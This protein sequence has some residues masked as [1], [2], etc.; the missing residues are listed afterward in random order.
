M[1]YITEADKRHIEGKYHPLD[2][3]YDPYNRF[4]YNGYDYD[5]E[6][7]MDNEKIKEGLYALLDELDAKGEHHHVTKA[8]GFSFILDNTRIDVNE[9][10][11]FVGFN[12]WN[13]IMS[14]H[15]KWLKEVEQ[16]EEM[17]R[18]KALRDLCWDTGIITMWPDFDHTTPD[19]DAV[20]K[21]GFPGLLA[22]AEFYKEKHRRE[23]T[24]DSEKEAVFDGVI[25]TYQSI[26]RLINRFYEYSLTHG[27]EKSAEISACLK[28][29][30]EGAPQNTY[31][32]L[33][34]IYLYFMF[35]ESVDYYQ[36][37]TLGYGL[38][39]AIYPYMVKDIEEGR[40]TR[41]QIGTFIAHF[42]M[43]FSAIGNYWGQPFYLGGKHPDGRTKINE[44]S[45][46]IVEVYDELDIY[47]PKMQLKLDRSTP[48]DFRNK[49]LD[50]VRR[51]NGIF[52][53]ICEDGMV[54]ALMKS[55]H[56]YEEAL[57]AVITGCYEVKPKG[58]NGSGCTHLNMVKPLLLI[59]NGGKDEM[60]GKTL[61]DDV[62]P[63]AEL[64]TY[65]EFYREYIR[66]VSHFAEIAM[67]LED[68]YDPY[69]TYCNPANMMTGAYEEALIKGEDAY[70]KGIKNGS[71]FLVCSFASAV[72]SLMAVKK[73]VYEGNKITLDELRDILNAN[74]EGN[75]KLMMLAR[76]LPNKYGNADPE[77]DMTAK[78]LAAYIC[79]IVNGRPNKKNGRY[80]TL[81][82]SAR[83]FIVHGEKT[84]AT[85]DGRMAGYELSK[86]AS[87]VPGMDK[88]GVTAL[89]RSALSMD[90]SNFTSDFCV[91]VMLHPSA[92]EGDEGLA[93]LN[94]ILDTYMNGGGFAIHFNIMNADVLRDAQKNPEKYKNLQVRV[95][96]WNTLWN[97]MARSEQEAYILRA[98]N[99]I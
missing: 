93:V 12:C 65:D 85:P 90:P 22:R 78:G 69:L 88:N 24:L 75:E 33:Q 15:R 61:I 13:R 62:K 68:A 79:N 35:S 27:G 64:K 51:R 19:W 16:N 98:E 5:P 39:A 56:S 46:L 86:N 4:G 8:K 44:A 52:V 3:S 91:D 28:R 87:P 25:L 66:L 92:V 18:I 99:I 89:I 9:Y 34:I 63:L 21:L 40:Y 59:L 81:A 38:D 47:N 73:L 53:F 32:V 45:H 14:P 26:M 80:G 10:D 74:W 97:N 54:N 42:L 2:G 70:F 36:V 84:G 48:M 57:D 37:R 83:Q 96:G 58:A 77:T 49:V 60:T 82:H 30:S 50:M 71:G 72:D 20:F 67:E 94:G 31:D 7:G 55:G 76:S 6:S 43:Q 29:L 41:D 1:K 11:Y 23:G 17:K 95:C